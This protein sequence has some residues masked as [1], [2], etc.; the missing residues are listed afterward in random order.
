MRLIALAAFAGLLATSAHANNYV[1]TQVQI[2]GSP[3]ACAVGINDSNNVI[4]EYF[5]EGN[6]PFGGYLFYPQSSTQILFNPPPNTGILDSCGYVAG[7]S[8]IGGHNIGVATYADDVHHSFAPFTFNPKT[9]KTKKLPKLLRITVPTAINKSGAIT[10]TTDKNNTFAGHGF[11]ISGGTAQQFDAPGATGTVPTDIADDG[12]IVGYYSGSGG[13]HGFIRTP[14]GTFR[15]VDVP[16]SS[17][18][19]I[20]SINKDGELAG[21]YYDSTVEHYVGFV[22][23]GAHVETYQ[24]PGAGNTEIMR[25]LANGLRIGNY[26][27]SSSV[28]HGFSFVPNIY[29]TLSAPGG[30][31]M[32]VR[33]VNSAGNFAGNVG[34]ALAGTAYVAI[35]P[36]HAGTCSN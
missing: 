3:Y 29:T 19:E 12:T 1:Y 33:A 9:G 8:D 28:N 4:G 32:W 14:A 20:L 2:T 34:G 31:A 22:K 35:C 5:G 6:A 11:V 24:Y 16:G 15:S 30:A 13:T 26:E 17:D 10:G 21:K 36:P 27:D 23:S 7:I 25:A 18:T